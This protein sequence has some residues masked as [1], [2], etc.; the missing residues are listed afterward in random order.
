MGPVSRRTMLT[1]GRVRS[2]ACAGRAAPFKGGQKW[3]KRA[4]PGCFRLAI[5]LVPLLVV[6]VV[7]AAIVSAHG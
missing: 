4:Q 3:Q 7:L 6:A 5:R 2:T 1:R